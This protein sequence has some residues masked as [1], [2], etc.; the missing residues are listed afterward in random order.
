MFAIWIRV[1]TPGLSGFPRLLEVLEV[2]VS[3]WSSRSSSVVLFLG[4]LRTV[5]HMRLLGLEGGP[6]FA[7]C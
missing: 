6:Q 7:C 3:S 1:N 5:T 2:F 4:T